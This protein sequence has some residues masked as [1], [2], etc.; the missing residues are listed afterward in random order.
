MVIYERSDY[1]YQLP[2]DVQQSIRRALTAKLSKSYHRSE[3]RDLVEMGMESRLVDLE[4][5]IDY[6]KYL[7]MANDTSRKGSS[8]KN[9]ASKRR[10]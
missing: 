9:V 3:L 1:V 2:V 7:D 5:T 4:D 6:R 10:F 8:R